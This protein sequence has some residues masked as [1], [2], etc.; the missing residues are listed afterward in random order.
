[1][2]SIR[3]FLH[4]H[5]HLDEFKKRG[6]EVLGCSIDTEHVHKAWKAVEKA[7]GGLGTAINHPMLADVNKDIARRYGVLLEEAGVTVRGVVVID[8]EG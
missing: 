3:T 6:A 5:K 1:M 4:F 8:K 7:K 2:E